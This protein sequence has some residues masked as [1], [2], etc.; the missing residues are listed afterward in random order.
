MDNNEFDL[1]VLPVKDKVYTAP[2]KRKIDPRL[3]DIKV[4]AC[5]G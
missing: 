2:L 5:C 1:S 3:P 4:G